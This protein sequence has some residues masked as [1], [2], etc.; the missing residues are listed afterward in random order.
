MA[1]GVPVVAYDL[2]VFEEVFPRAMKKVTLGD[3]HGFAQAI[4]ELL[5]N[6]DEYEKLKLEG[7]HL[8]SNYDWEIVSKRVLERLSSLATGDPFVNS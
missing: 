7:L 2:P 4:L 1:S 6:K 8:A 3:I 5:E